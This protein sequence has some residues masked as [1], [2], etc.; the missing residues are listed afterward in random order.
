MTGEKLGHYEILDKIG[1]GGMGQV[2]R[3]RDARL[4]RSVAIKIL[5]AEVAGDPVRRQRFEQEA[6]SL[7]ALNHPNIVS[8]YDIGQSDGRAYIVSEL[9]EGESL[10]TVLE[11]GALMGRSLIETAAQIAEAL[12][13]AH[14][15]GIVHRDVKPE[16]I[17]VAAPQSGAP[18]RVKVLDFGL[19]KQNAPQ[20]AGEDAATMLLSQPGMV[21]GTVGYMSPEQVRGENV[22]PRS[23]IFS[24]GCVLYEMAT[25]K[26]AFEGGSA[27]D[28]MS[29]V[30]REEPRGLSSDGAPG[31]AGAMAPAL[32]AIV[33]RC[34]EKNPALRFQ[35]AADMAFALRALAGTTGSQAV[36]A[37]PAVTAPPK[38]RRKPSWAIAAALVALALFAGGYR[39]RDLSLGGPPEFHRITFREGRV[40]NARFGPDGRSVIYSA[41]WESGQ[42]GIYVSN[43]ANPVSRDL[44]LPDGRLLAVSSKGDLAF[45]T[46]TI[47]PDGS[48]T[49]ARNSISGGET[50]ELLEHVRLADWSPDGSELAVVRQV[51]GKGRLEYPVGKMLTETI[52]GPFSIRISP[53]G[54]TVAFTTYDHGSSIAIYTVDRAGKV[55]KLGVVSGQT[56]GFE[57]GALAWSPDGREIWFRSFDP[58]DRNTIYAIGLDGKRR[59]AARFPGYLALYDIAADGRI[60]F[61]LNNGRKGIRALAPGETVERDLSI[62]ESADVRGISDDGT[63]ILAETVGESGGAKG[64]IYLRHT[65]GSPPV[66]LGDGVAFSLSPDGKWVTGYTSRESAVRQFILMPTGPGETVEVHVPQ[67]PDG[68]GLV[69]GWLEGEEN[70]LVQGASL[71]GKG[72]QYFAWNARANT[73]TP[74][75]P[76]NAPDAMPLLS[77]DRHSYLLPCAA[78]P[79]CVYSMDG[80]NRPPEPRPVLGLTPHDSP[81]NW[82][83]DGKAIYVVTHHNDNRMMPITLI[84][85]ATGNR[86]PWKELRPAIP[87][88]QVMY[89][90][91][92]PDGRGY[93]YNYTYVRSELYV[94]EGVK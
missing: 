88:D 87:V 64:S 39:L 62:L 6:R 5:P 51:D 80:P 10:R 55:R 90:R 67:L 16:N 31:A 66:R 36:P 23:D 78:G 61:S 83:A 7:G 50:R 13:A 30:L 12:A 34:L 21:L 92:T 43:V 45:L 8:V 79:W 18:G 38:K 77:P 94:G 2:W 81:V 11:R 41:S 57:L 37:Q 63:V 75:S 20:A 46:G 3:A 60:L 4:N 52:W 48:G 72:W 1:E 56:S 32:Q 35:S 19:A 26:R 14:A 22:D 70:Y 24:F 59:V 49:L 85:L 53:S 17:M 58:N 68:Q 33:R 44:E 86:T 29:A 40:S 89:P 76:P 42:P 71:T 25:G 47:F 54:R 73:V 28:V 9:V 74:V 15:L 69:V 93:A 27:A 82:R 65:D 91:I 84:D